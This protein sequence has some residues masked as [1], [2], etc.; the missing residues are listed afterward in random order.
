M[1][2]KRIPLFN[3]FGFEI[4]LD[5]SWIIIAV[6]ITWTLAAGVFPA[7]YPD[8]QPG[9]Y[10]SMGVIAALALFGSII[11][12]ETAH[13]AVARRYGLPINGIT[14]FVFGGVAEMEREPDSPGVEFLMAVAGP[15][16]SYAIAFVCY[17]A[18]LGSAEAGV[19]A[20]V[21]GV[22]GYLALINAIIATF[23]LVP[24]FPLDGGRI[25]RAALWRWK[26]EVRWA[27]QVTSAI[28]AGFGL[29][30]IVLGVW[31]VLLGDFIGGMWW[32]L[33]GLFVRQAA[34]MSYQ[35]VVVREGLRGVPVHRI[36]SRDP[37]TVPPSVSLAQ[38]VDDWIYR[39][40]YKM[41]PVVEDG[42]LVGC[43]SLRD[44]KEVPR[45]NWAETSVA[46]I[47]RGCGPE[48]SVS[49]DQDALAALTVMHRTQNGRLLVIEGGRLVGVVT[50]K[51][52]L[53]FLSLK[54]DLEGESAADRGLFGLGSPD[55]AALRPPDT[56][57]HGG[58]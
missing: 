47:T 16:A 5:W 31:R 46:S 12:H 24:A 33:I 7:N 42:R 3:L 41:F 10:W 13:A 1:F 6:L 8:L 54:L 19:P 14:L 58:A 20:P 34:Q 57:R 15:I 11:L 35:Q 9:T 18:A 21:V 25:L 22:L 48:N 4:R 28:G 2:G 39:H 36:M 27:T 32:F 40:H 37:V 56:G 45:E 52:M 43:I 17:M 38:L 26:G 23:N 50:M 53:K 30:L 29:L 44:V 49:P 51:D 55:R